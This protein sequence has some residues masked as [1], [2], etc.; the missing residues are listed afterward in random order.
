[1]LTAS[2]KQL[3]KLLICWIDLHVG[4]ESLQRLSVDECLTLRDGLEG[5]LKVHELLC[6][7]HL[8]DWDMLHTEI[9]T[10]LFCLLHRLFEDAS[11]VS[12]AQLWHTWQLVLV[13]EERFTILLRLVVLIVDLGVHTSLRL[14]LDPLTNEKLVLLVIEVTTLA[15]AL[16]A[17]PVSLKMVTVTFSEHTVAIAFALVPLSLKDVLVGVDHATLTLRQAVHPVAIVPVSILVEEG[18]TSVLLVLIPVACVLTAQLAAA[19]VLPVGTLAVAL[20]NG[21]HA[22]VL[23]AILVEL[24]AEALLAV[25]PPVTN[26]LLTGLP[27]LTL[28]S[29]ILRLILLLDPVHGPM[30]SVLLRLCIVT[31]VTKIVA[32]PGVSQ[33][34]DNRQADSKWDKNTLI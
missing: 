31:K 24:D 7:E 9:C 28:D 11:R 30:G 32:A 26:V 2:L 4:E 6:S 27:L 18:A 13:H 8:F 19:L 20:V 3:V 12:K 5:S 14:V 21:P 34:F 1:M 17:H 16:I 10:L 33:R 25:V 29:A 15:L 22:L 23:V